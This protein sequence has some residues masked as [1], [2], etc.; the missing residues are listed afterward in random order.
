MWEDLLKFGEGAWESVSEGVT[1]YVDGAI[2]LQLTKQS[3]QAKDPDVLKA[4]EPEKAKRTDGSTIVAPMSATATRQT[5]VTGVDN[6]VVLVGGVV[7]VALL[8]MLARGGK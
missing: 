7:V 5:L 2:D 3:E 8:L 4:A 6:T 1:Q